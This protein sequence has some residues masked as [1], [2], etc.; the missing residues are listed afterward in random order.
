MYYPYDPAW[1]SFVIE[2]SREVIKSAIENYTE[3]DY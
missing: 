1:R 2:Q 3:I